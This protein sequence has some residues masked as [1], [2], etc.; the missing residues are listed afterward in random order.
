MLSGVKPFDG[1]T[2]EALMRQHLTETPA[3]LDQRLTSLP[4]RVVEL[5]ARLLKKDPAARPQRASDVIIALRESAE[6]L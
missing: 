6:R 4:P 5:V 2:P 3:S 1:T